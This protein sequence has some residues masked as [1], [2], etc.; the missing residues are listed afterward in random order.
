[1]VNDECFSLDLSVH[2]NSPVSA[3]SISL[4]GGDH[5][6]LTTCP[7]GAALLAENA[8][9]TF[10]CLDPA[11]AYLSGLPATAV[12]P[13]SLGQTTLTLNSPGVYTSAAAL[14]LAGEL[15]L[16]GGASDIWIFQITGA[17]TTAADFKM[18]LINGALPENVFWHIVGA[19]S[20]G[21]DSIMTGTIM[22]TGAITMGA[23]ATSGALFTS[24]G[25]ITM[26]ADATST[27]ALIAAG[28]VSMGASA[29]ALSVITPAAVTL[30]AAAAALGRLAS[31]LGGVTL[32]PGEY[33]SGT[34]AVSLTGTLY[35]NAAIV[36][37]GDAWILRVGGAFTAAA[38]SQMVFVDVGG[39]TITDTAII[40]G[41]AAQVKWVVTGAIT[42][43]AGSQTIGSMESTAG[44]ITMGAGASIIGTLTATT[45]AVTLGA[46]ASAPGRLPG[47]LGGGTPFGPGIYDSGTSAVG[48]AGILYLNAQGVALNA[49]IAWS[50]IIGGAFTAA[51]GSKVVFVDDSNPLGITNA[52]DIKTLAAKVKW[53]VTGAIAFG[54]QSEMVG[55][56]LSSAG[57]ISLGAGATSTGALTATIGAVTLG[58]GASAPG[59]LAGNVGGVTLAPGSYNSDGAVGL[60]GILK[61][62]TSGSDPNMWTFTIGGAST[63]AASSKVIFVDVNGDEI[64][65]AADITALASNVHWQVTGAIT[66][67]A[68]SHVI[69]SMTSSAG[70]ISLGAGAST[71]GQLT[72]TNG[73][74]VL[75]LDASCVGTT[76][77]SP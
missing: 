39:A 67:G 44:A 5:R 31:D 66:L 40:A 35:L 60:S 58:A 52:A 72:A 45:G 38:D 7:V 41:F 24:A 11:M 16:D 2:V 49:D 18:I 23:R 13:F 33:N 53:E 74:V 48:L 27:G 46:D 65:N 50:F 64:T 62:D 73:A 56:M 21:A 68:D 63:T 54:A 8:I 42:L 34:S 20:L 69:G 70:A 22:A 61:L 3:V 4:T 55:S 43:A 17:L 15:I 36:P 71:T 1:M 32:G 47:T 9:T 28:A 10:A 30:G 77:C 25:A 51:A 26:G 57:A 6:V 37:A 12:Y 14:S 19:A 29:S 59:R 75:G 76:P